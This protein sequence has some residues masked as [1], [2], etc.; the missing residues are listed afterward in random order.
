[1]DSSCI[2]L[3]GQVHEQSYAFLHVDSKRDRSL[4]NSGAETHGLL[5]DGRIASVDATPT[6]SADEVVDANLQRTIE[7][8]KQ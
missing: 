5:K 3:S 1:M 2:I 4:P 6:T 7:N 8:S